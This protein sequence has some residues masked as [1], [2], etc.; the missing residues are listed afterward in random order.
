LAGQGVDQSS[1]LII[2]DRLR[3]ELF[4]TGS[5][6][7]LE[8]GAMQDILKEQG[9]QQSGCTSDQCIVQ[10]GQMLGVTHIVAG[11]VGKLGSMY[12]ISV[13]LIEVKS[14]KIIYSD[15][16]D[17]KCQ[18][19]EVLTGSVPAI[20]RK[21]AQSIVPAPVSLP[22]TPPAPQTG[23]LKVESKP[24]G[25]QVLLDDS[26]K[27][28]TPYQ[29]EKMNVGEYRLKLD[30]AGFKPIE[31]KIVIMADK[32]TNKSYKLEH[33]QQ[34]QDSVAALEKAA[35]AVSRQGGKPVRKHSFVP[36]VIFGVAAAGAAVAGVLVDNMVKGKINNDATI[37][38]EYVSLDDPSR[39]N[40]YRQKLNDNL[41]QA[42]SSQTTRNICYG[43][44]GACIIGFGVSFAF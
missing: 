20:A 39:A 24:D 2:S 8:R 22:A 23:I 29:N 6:T 9:F 26:A 34:W 1:S 11:I 32:T 16:V 30:M 19:E 40:E 3:N 10:I 35:K 27:G 12:T 28:S 13:R 31:E 42:K 17:C 4:K 33:T 43:L 14:G 38:N 7:V 25:A 15:N 41:N 5:C 37:K 44:A 21:I 18:I 36:K